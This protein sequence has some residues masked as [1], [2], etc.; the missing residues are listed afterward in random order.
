MVWEY[1]IEVPITAHN[2]IHETFDQVSL[3]TANSW[4]MISYDKKNTTILAH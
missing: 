4:Q 2:L 3:S 1:K